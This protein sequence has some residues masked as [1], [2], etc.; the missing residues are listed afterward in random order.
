MVT[1]M[2]GLDTRASHIQ[3][4]AMEQSEIRKAIDRCGTPQVLHYEP[5]LPFR[6]LS[7]VD[8]QSP[9]PFDVIC[10]ARS[11]SFTP[12]ESDALST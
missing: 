3:L 9:D 4:A 10:L 2:E 5:R 1:V 7:W 8:F 6:T 11:P 12:P